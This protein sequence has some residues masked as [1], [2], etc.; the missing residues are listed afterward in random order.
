M[1]PSNN[2]QLE[3]VVN[4]FILY[5]SYGQYCDILY[6]DVEVTYDTCLNDYV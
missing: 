2:E 6:S 3:I 4:A 1:S 5:S